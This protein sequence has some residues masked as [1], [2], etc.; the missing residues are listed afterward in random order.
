M[1]LGSSVLAGRLFT[2]STNYLVY[3]NS[4][5][6][7]FYPHDST[8]GLREDPSYRFMS[9]SLAFPR[10]SGTPICLKICSTFLGENGGSFEIDGWEQ[11]NKRLLERAPEQARKNSEVSNNIQLCM[12]VKKRILPWEVHSDIF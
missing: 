12:S 11:K 10:D 7:R 5:S 2:T 4:Q 8:T 3:P 1:S 9:V 6:S